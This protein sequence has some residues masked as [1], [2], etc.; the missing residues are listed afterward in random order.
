MPYPSPD[1]VPIRLWYHL[2]NPQ[3]KLGG[4]KQKSPENTTLTS[5]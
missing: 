1:V 3:A 4:G 2:K 5:E